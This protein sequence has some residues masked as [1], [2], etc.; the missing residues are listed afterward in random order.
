MKVLKVQIL[1]NTE[2]FGS[3]GFRNNGFLAIPKLK[4]CII[5]GQSNGF[6]EITDKM[7]IPN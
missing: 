2:V 3:T 7:A 1:K 4:F 6:P 5:K